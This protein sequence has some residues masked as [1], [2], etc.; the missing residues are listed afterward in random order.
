MDASLYIRPCL[1]VRSSFFT[2]PNPSNNKP[3]RL[4]ALIVV[5]LCV[6]SSVLCAK[7]SRF[8]LRTKSNNQE[9]W[10]RTGT[11]YSRCGVWLNKHAAWLD[12]AQWVGLISAVQCTGRCH[13]CRVVTPSQRGVFW[14]KDH[15]FSFTTGS[16]STIIPWESFNA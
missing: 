8:Y 1:F 2:S 3:H 16:K 4:Y 6:C 5:N 11:H 7:G 14:K 9:A 13:R 12:G 15:K 10:L